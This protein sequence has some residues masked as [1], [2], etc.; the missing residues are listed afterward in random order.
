M[1][2]AKA[3]AR[4]KGTGARAK[5]RAKTS[6]K[7]AAAGKGTA[8]AMAAQQVVRGVGMKATGALTVKSSRNT[9]QTWMRIEKGKVCQL[10]FPNPRSVNSLQPEERNR[11]RQTADGDYGDCEVTGLMCDSNDGDGDC[12]ML[13]I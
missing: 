6:A 5:G 1:A 7:A 10:L 11:G 12:D 8:R 2:R 13:E 4:G 3:R 9:R